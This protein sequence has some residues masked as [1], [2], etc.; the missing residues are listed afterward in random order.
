MPKRNKGFLKIEKGAVSVPFLFIVNSR[1]LRHSRLV[2]MPAAAA[3][4]SAARRTLRGRTA[5]RQFGASLG[6]GFHVV[7]IITQ[8]PDSFPKFVHV[9]VFCIKSDG[10]FRTFH[11]VGALFHPRP[12]WNVLHHN[13]FAL[14]ARSVGLNCNSL[15]LN[16]LLCKKRKYHCTQGNKRED[17]FHIGVFL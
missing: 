8:M 12:L 6:I 13:F 4:L 10:D 16:L 5:L 7:S 9:R 2:M 15:S 1:V 14:F 17:F 11:V 3:T